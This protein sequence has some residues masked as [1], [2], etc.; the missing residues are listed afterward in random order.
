MKKVN[1]IA[2]FFLL[3]G[4]SYLVSCTNDMEY[5]QANGV[6]SDALIPINIVV[7]EY[8]DLEDA[9]PS[10]RSTTDESISD[11]QVFR[12]DVPDN[13]DYE[14]VTTVEEAPIQEVQTRAN[15]EN[16]AL[17][18]MLIYNAN[19]TQISDCQYRVNGTTATLV[20]GNAPLL[21]EGTYKFV[22]YTKNASTITTDNP[23]NVYNGEDFATYCVTK[24]VSSTNNTV[25]ISFV[26]QIAQFQITASAIGFTNNTV[27]FTSAEVT[28]LATSGVWN[29]SAASNDQTGLSLN[30]SAT[31]PCANNVAYRGLPIQ[32]EISIT[33]KGVSVDGYNKGDRTVKLTTNFRGGKR[34]I[35]TVNFTKKTAISVAGLI[36]APGNLVFIN[37][38]YTFYDHQ[39]TYLG[40]WNSGNYFNFNLLDPL[41]YQ[42]SVS[43]N[44][45]VPAN[46]PCRKVAPAGKWRT[47]TQADMEALVRTTSRWGQLNNINGR[48]FG[49]EDQL[50]LPATGYR[51][52]EQSVREV[53]TSGLYWTSTPIPNS[54][55]AV[56]MGI[57]SNVA[58]IDN[59]GHRAMGM[60]V[61]CVAAAY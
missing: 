44:Y 49:T 2:A 58:H 10:T 17:F 21:A 41:N 56:C 26:R 53:S 50:F 24:T 3:L 18:R 9:T 40:L 6:A 30:G 23:V 42:Q 20:S 31:Y 11:I 34:Y 1:H 27:S 47:P 28:N 36:W 59:R 33:L 22:C 7:Q 16:N 54:G 51:Y 43:G 37:G 25:A 13:E 55:S 5:D 19:G 52:K 57:N 61:R 29:V 4:T 48:F 39:E 32:R 38:V 14:M 60:S 15:M 46:D 45:W 12:Q 8:Q 35:I